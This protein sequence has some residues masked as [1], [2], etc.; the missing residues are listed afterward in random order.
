MFSEYKYYGEFS[1]AMLSLFT[2]TI[3]KRDFEILKTKKYSA[4][5]HLKLISE[6]QTF[7]I[8]QSYYL[9]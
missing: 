7:C 2:L 9:N 4:Y 3:L 6:I 1:F 5:S 8:K